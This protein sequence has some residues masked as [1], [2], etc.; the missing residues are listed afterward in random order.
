ME[1]DKAPANNRKIQR[2][3]NKENKEKKVLSKKVL[4]NLSKTI[5]Y[6]SFQFS[7]TSFQI[8]KFITKSY[9]HHKNIAKN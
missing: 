5:A 4:Q 9:T 3:K 1:S 7:F 8:F 2:A 6:Y